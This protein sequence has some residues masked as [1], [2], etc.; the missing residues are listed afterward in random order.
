MS[1]AYIYTRVSTLQQT[2]VFG[3]FGIDRQITTIMDFLENATLPKELGYQLDP[4]NYEVLDSDAGVSGFKG[5][6][7]TKGSLGRFKSRVASGEISE[8]CLLIESVDRFSRKQGFDAIDEFTFLI[9]R[10]IDII[11]VETGQIFSYKLDHKLTQLSTSIERAYQESKRKS[12]MVTKSWANLKRK[13]VD[14]G[15]ALKRNIPYWL[16]LDGDNYQL[17]ETEVERIRSIFNSY[18]NGKGVTA[19]VRE[20]NKVGGKYDGKLFSTNFINVMLRD[21]RLIGWL[22]GKRK[23]SETQA[24][25]KSREIKI[26]PE[27]ISKELFDLVQRRID[28]NAV[29]K[30]IRNSTK[31]VSLFNGIARCGICNE[32]LIGHF[33]NKGNYLRC[34]GKRSKLGSCNS[35][36][37]RYDNCQRAIIEH[38]KSID[39]S[40]IYNSNNKDVGKIDT[41]QKRLNVVVAEINEIEIFLNTSET[42]AEIIPLTKAR[43]EKVSEK[44]RITNELSTLM[45]E[46]TIDNEELSCDIDEL[47]DKTNVELRERYNQSL[48]K[49]LRTIKIIQ[50]NNNDEKMF[51]FNFEYHHDYAM[52][53]VALSI[54]GEL[55]AYSY[56]EDKDDLSLKSSCIDINLKTG[57]I[58]TKHTPN[59]IET[60]LVKTTLISMRKKLIAYDSSI[61]IPEI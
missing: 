3:G 25:W 6:N 46:I 55:L 16:K 54:D 7:F 14:E 29:A 59:D 53:Y 28:A 40:M 56:I 41:L 48:K 58:N 32:P 30:T 38:V 22:T 15:I 57:E 9:K 27:I 34:L 10:N 18:A 45:K 17:N 52:H 37:I 21:R 36:L 23:S 5:H 31:Q 2:G 4:N 44:E 19:I 50:D 1:K 26:Y 20:L 51:I 47:C 11:E 24:E 42:H 33:T 61:E 60:L 13:A 39:F 12:R 8:G 49:V 43:R 35:S